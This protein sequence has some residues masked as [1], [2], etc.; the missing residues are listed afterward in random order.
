MAFSSIRIFGAPRSRIY[1]CSTSRR[2]DA[3]NLADQLQLTLYDAAYIELARRRTLP[4]AV[5]DQQLRTAATAIGVTV[6]GS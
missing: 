6:L 5:L 2:T 4:R 1:S 3:L